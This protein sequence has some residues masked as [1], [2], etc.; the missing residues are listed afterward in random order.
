[1][2][3]SEA[4]TGRTPVG[5][6][7]LESLFHRR[8]AR[9]PSRVD[10]VVLWVL[11]GASAG[12]SLGF[13]H[14]WLD[15]RHVAHL[16]AFLAL[17]L[18]F[19]VG[20][21]RG[22]LSLLP[23]LGLRPVP[24]PAAPSGLSVAVFVTAAPGEPL[25]MFETTLSALRDVR[26]PHR[27]YLL[28]G[29]GDPRFAE[30]AAS[31][32]AITLDMT[33]VADAKAGK[34]NR[35]LS[36]TTED[37]V[38]VLDPDHV[39]F[40]EFFERVLGHFEDARVGFVQ[41]AQGYYNQRRTFVARAAAEQT[42]GFYGPTQTGHG[43]LRSAIAIGANCTFRR[44]AL[45][46]I[47]G[48]AVGLAEDLITSIRL[49]AAGYHSVYVPEILSRGLVPE[50]LGAYF[51]QQ[52]KW[53]AGAVDLLFVEYPRWFG[54]LSGWQRASYFAVGTYYASG[55]GVLTYL[56]LPYLALWFGIVPARV[57]AGEFLA[58]GL[59][60]LVTTAAAHLFAQR[61]VC[62][63]A[64]ER[65]L[66]LRGMLLKAL[67][68]PIYVTGSLRA[69]CGALVRY[70]PTPK[71]ATRRPLVVDACAQLTILL[72][73]TVTLAVYPTLRLERYSL[74]ALWLA[75]EPFYTMLLIAF[76]SALPLALGLLLARRRAPLVRDA[77]RL[78]PLPLPREE[79]P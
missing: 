65:G 66:H 39:I 49:H 44:S 21:G 38:L 11:V 14:F 57:D 19:A 52:L 71:R 60:A 31:L 76:V 2:W 59:P 43:G 32:G 35:A 40:P 8:R 23:Y 27:T 47:G 13:L 18:A 26:Y 20:L 61:F 68:F 54:K 46:A 4:A 33:G 51:S 50:D 29:S 74:E 78:V 12:S 16:P 9:T 17:S 5:T 73:L 75:G 56:V 72:A 24:E 62:D 30:L 70:L 3:C 36:L 67:S 7:R 28:D 41:V 37:F 34:V 42:Y 15:A 77:W 79:T 48:H 58:A 1:M 64:V 45:R 53:A 6:S 55:F 69:L 10:R 63:E 22:T 25:S